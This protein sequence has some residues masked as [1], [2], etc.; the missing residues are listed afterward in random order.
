MMARSKDSGNEEKIFQILPVTCDTMNLGLRKR[1]ESWMTLMLSFPGWVALSKS[2]L[3]RRRNTLMK[4]FSRQL[5][6]LF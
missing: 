4:G 3:K 6:R 5:H 2:L 1:E